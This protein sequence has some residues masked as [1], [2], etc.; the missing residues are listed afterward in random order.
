[1]TER[2]FRSIFLVSCC[3]LLAC[4]II[5]MG[6]LY[7]Y[8]SDVQRDQLESELQLAAQGVENEGLAYFDGFKVDSLRLTWVAADGTVLYDSKADASEMENHLDREEISDALKV[9]TGRGERVSST[10]SERTYYLADRLSDGT[11]L[12]GSVTSYTIWVILFGM[13]YP[14]I[15]VIIV[16][17]VLSLL[18][19]RRISRR[20]I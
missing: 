19:A 15:V 4:L 16:A 12:R 6:A 1:M 13:L 8:F 5:I 18:L 7:D 3:V 9:G 11:V 14:I 10:L 20:I 2:I 17:V